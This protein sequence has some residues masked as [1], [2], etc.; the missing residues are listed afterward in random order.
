MSFYPDTLSLQ[1]TLQLPGMAR[2]HDSVV[3]AVQ[4]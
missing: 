2:T 1:G 4:Q 3:E